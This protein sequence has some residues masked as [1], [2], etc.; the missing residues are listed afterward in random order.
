MNLAL[1][2]STKSIYLLTVNECCKLILHGN[3]SAP[4]FRYIETTE[5]L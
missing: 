3:R 5:K 1:M 2:K 4:K